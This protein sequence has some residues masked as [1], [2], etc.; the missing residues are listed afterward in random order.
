MQGMKNLLS[1]RDC[2]LLFDVPAA[3][4]KFQYLLKSTSLLFVSVT[5]VLLSAC[6]GGG[7]GDGSA[8]G[9]RTGEEKEIPRGDALTPDLPTHNNLGDIISDS[10]SIVTIR[11]VSTPFTPRVRS[12]TSLVGGYTGA[13]TETSDGRVTY[14]N[15]IRTPERFSRLDHPRST[16]PRVINQSNGTAGV[17]NIEIPWK[18]QCESNPPNFLPKPPPTDQHP[19]LF[20]N[21]AAKSV[22]ASC[23]WTERFTQISSC[24]P[25]IIGLPYS[26]TGKIEIDYSWNWPLLQ[27]PPYIKRTAT[28]KP[29]PING[30]G[31]FVVS[32]G[33]T[34]QTFTSTVTE[35]STETN[36]IEFSESL[37]K[38]GTISGGP[39]FVTASATIE[40]EITDSFSNTVTITE[41]TE[42]EESINYPAGGVYRRWG[43]EEVYEFVHEDGTPYND[44]SYQFYE[45]DKP[46]IMLSTKSFIVNE[47][48]ES[49]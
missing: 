44:P 7:G 12:V 16:I 20:E 38:S 41:Q 10:G 48:G 14:T 34:N 13:W 24:A 45:L 11:P 29:I 42:Y 40:K 15:A 1:A 17:R 21:G 32:T 31:T 47:S 25:L 3:L 39:R 23:T 19:V 6:G 22:G 46:F 30:R 35:G 18:G 26:C 4:G 27:K 9:G 36:T 28:W 8:D 2:S 37:N 43:L 5:V 49:I 33:T